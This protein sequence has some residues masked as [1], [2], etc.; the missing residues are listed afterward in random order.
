[1]GLKM[2][3]LNAPLEVIRFVVPDVFPAGYFAFLGAREGV[4]KTTILAGLLWQMSRPNG[5]EF[6]GWRV[7]HGSSIY[8][9]TDAPDGQ[10]RTVRHWL[11]KHRAA[12]PDGDLSKISVFEPSDSGLAPGDL[13]SIR[14]HALGNGV[15]AIVIDSYM[16]AFPGLDINRLEQTMM[17]LSGLREL[18]ARTKAAVIVTDHIPKRAPGEKDG[19]RG[20]M[21]SVAKSAQARAVHILSRVD[22][23]DCDGQNML[24]WEVHKQSFAQRL[25]PFGVRL[26]LE[27]DDLEPSKLVRVERCDL[28][29]QNNGQDRAERSVIEFLEARAGETFLRAR[30]LEVAVTG[31]NVKER[32]AIEAMTRALGGFG[33]RLEVIKG[34]GKGAPLSYR[35]KPL[36]KTG[37]PSNSSEDD[38]MQPLHFM[39]SGVASNDKPSD[40]HKPDFMQS[41]TTTSPEENASMLGMIASNAKEAVQ[42]DKTFHAVPIASNAVTALN[43]EAKLTPELETRFKT[44]TLSSQVDRSRR[45][46]LI[47][48]AR[49]GNTAALEQLYEL[50]ATA[51]TKSP[52]VK[53]ELETALKVEA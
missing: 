40:T 31:G 21:G 46:G 52:K 1:M 37:E 51:Q 19:D 27:G 25:E 6:L 45:S 38:L 13:E 11:E 24:R 30:V 44:M 17:P 49:N 23:K 48:S 39:Q 35:L 10:S 33:D 22:A 8:V 7:P 32:T 5:G 36:P 12:Y 43:V 53:A 18:A 9:N 29:G 15:Q 34:T 41:E 42:H 26:V 14:E 3:N 4:G 20:I 28:P 2:V 47:E 50:E 16:G